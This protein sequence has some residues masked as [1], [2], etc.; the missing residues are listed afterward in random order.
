M[1][2]TI[3]WEAGADNPKSRD[4]GKVFE[5]I[6]MSALRAERWAMRALTALSR[7][8]VDVAG[9]TPSMGM[10]GVAA[11]GLEALMKVVGEDYVRPLMDEMLTCVKIV[12]SGASA[13]VLPRPLTEDDIE[14][15]DTLLRLRLEVVQ[16]HLGFSLAEFSQR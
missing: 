3:R 12:P 7:S 15:V 9:V 2:K 8:G 13:G 16:L 1:R 10:Q 14:E 6:E 11:M 4:A 5:I